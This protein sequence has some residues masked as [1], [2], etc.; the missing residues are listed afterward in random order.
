M[1]EKLAANLTGNAIGDAASMDT[2]IKELMKA[3][4]VSEEVTKSLVDSVSLLLDTNLNTKSTAKHKDIV[5]RLG[6]ASFNSL[7]TFTQ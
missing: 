2:V 1:L 3:D 7:F 4:T 6:R 5:N